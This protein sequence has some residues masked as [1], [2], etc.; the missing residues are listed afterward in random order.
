MYLRARIYLAIYAA[1]IAL[2]IDTRSILPLLFVG[3]PNLF[4]TWLMPVYGI[5]STPA[6]PRMSSTTGSTAGRS[7]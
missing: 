1:V 6:W 5:P 3:L 7:I 2:A 4:G